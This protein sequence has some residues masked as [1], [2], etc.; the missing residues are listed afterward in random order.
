MTRKD[1]KRTSRAKSAPSTVPDMDQLAKLA[2]DMAGV[3]YWRYA[4]DRFDWSE[5][6]YRIYGLDPSTPPP[7]MQ[8][9]SDFCY[10]DD[11]QKVA[12]HNKTYTGVDAP[13]LEFRLQRPDGEIR[14]VIT[15]SIVQQDEDGRFIGR[16]GTIV[17]VTDIKLAEAAARENEQRYQ[18]IADNAAEMIAR[19]A[20]NGEMRYVSPSSIRV[21]GYTPEEHMRMTPQ[22]M[23]HPDDIQRIGIAIMAMVMNRKTHLDEPLRYRAKHKSGEWIWIES[24]PTLILDAHGAPI[25]TIDVIRDVTQAMLNRTEL[26]EAKERAET[27]AAAKSAF[28]ANMSHELRTPLTSIVGFSRLLSSRTDLPQ[29]ASH[30]AQRISDASDALLTI[31]N[32]VLDFSKL[33]AG[34][35]VMEALPLSLPRLL[36]ETTGFIAM[37]AADK[38]VDVRVKIAPATPEMI[39]GDVARLRQVLV[40]LLSNA[41][42]FTD[43]GSITVQTAYRKTK[44]GGRLKVSVADTGAGVAPESLP[45]LF[46]RFSQAD[47]SIN[48]T[49]GGTGLGLAISKGIIEAMGGKIGVRTK[50]GEGSTFWFVIPAEAAAAQPEHATPSQV[51]ECPPLRLLVVDDTPVNRELVRLILTPLGLEVQEAAGGAEGVSAALAKPFDVILMDV[52]MPGIDGL[53]AT[54]MIR[55]TS[56]FNRATPILALTADVE[57]QN[58]R[59]CLEAGMNDVLAKPI[60]PQMLLS[61][62]LEWAQAGQD[63]EDAPTRASA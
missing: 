35:V 21:F 27:A 6:A 62:I 3:G 48:R 11:R 24:N 13:P 30:Y 4:D 44:A 23:T 29:E 15:R 12:D 56:P 26:E 57:P 36:E 22:D 55:A 17:D 54:R 53:E 19:T 59:A 51:E 25:E 40:N 1:K 52:R 18:F 7:T 45:R 9:L 16:F 41:V 37:Q 39:V 10:P 31:I 5:Q 47:V 50:A 2:V 63:A 42:K 49:H 43:H 34:Q 33:D 8:T 14:H 28:L 61:K 60:V 58:A 20:I 32:D 38:G 46:G